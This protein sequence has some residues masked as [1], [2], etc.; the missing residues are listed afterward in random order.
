MGC[1]PSVA[2][3]FVLIC[4]CHHSVFHWILVNVVQPGQKR[5]LVRNQRFPVVHPNPPPRSSLFLVDPPRRSSME[6]SQPAIK[7]ISTRRGRVSKKVIVIRKNNPC[8][9][10]PTMLRRRIHHGVHNDLSV[11]VRVEKMLT[12]IGGSGD[13]VGSRR[14]CPVRR[15]MGP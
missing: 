6:V 3:P 8:L 15:S 5:G 2:R 4:C 11:L 1:K 10:L 7:T 14:K 12:V 13:K 9:H